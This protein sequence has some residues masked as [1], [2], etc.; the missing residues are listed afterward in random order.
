[1]DDLKIEPQENQLVDTTPEYSHED[2]KKESFRDIASNTE[3][4]DEPKEE[5]PIEEQKEE[6]KVEFDEEKYKKIADE[7]AV[8]AADEVERRRVEAEKANEEPK[9]A[10][11]EYQEIVDEFTDR[12]G[13]TP[14]WDELAVKIEE[15]TIEKIEAR[16]VE[17]T[18]AEIQEKET[19]RKTY[20]EEQKRIDVFV[21]DEMAELYKHQKLTPIREK[22]NPSDQGVVERKSFF[23]QWGDVN[24]QRRNE[25]KPEI[26][27][28]T[29]IYEYYYKKP[30]AQPAGY[31]APIAG[32][33]GSTI[34][35]TQ[36]QEY[37]NADLKKPW[38]FFRGGK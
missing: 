4:P 30:S 11:T 3:I 2:L 33:R 13:R 25:G 29:R 23:K 35:P 6:P 20:E 7:A 21:D 32:N 16:Q 37:S 22:D 9:E 17:K 34:S 10:K 14:T 26:L 18:Q 24:T 27:S 15:R 5:T 19:Q 38:S 8:R 12:E 31:D 36:E 28:A 1:M